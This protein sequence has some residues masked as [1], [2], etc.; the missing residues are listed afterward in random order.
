MG[1]IFL[2][3]QHQPRAEVIN[4]LGRDVANLFR[5]LQRHY[6]QFLDVLKFQLT[7]RVEFDRLSKTDPDMRR[8]NYGQC[9]HNACAAHGFL[10]KLPMLFG[11]ALRSAF[12]LS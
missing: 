1:G 5:I 4:D 7:T 8:A 11:L 6:P 9:S 10:S 2:K 3:R 12:L